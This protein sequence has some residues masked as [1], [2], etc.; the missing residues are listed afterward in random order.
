MYIGAAVLL[1]LVAVGIFFF[2]RSSATPNQTGLGGFFGFGS[3]VPT[4]QVGTSTTNTPQPTN[5]TSQRIFKIADGPVAGAAFI[6]TSNPTTTVVRYAMADNGHV[7]DKPIDVPGAI[8]SP[9]SNVTIPGI[10]SSVWATTGSST[11]MQYFDSGVLK[12]V[13]IELGSTTASSSSVTPTRVRFLPNNI[14][15]L[16]LS[17]TNSRL[18]YVLV[19]SNG[20]VDGY[21]SNL[22]GTNV[23]LAFS[24]PLSQVLLSWPSPG[25]LLLQTK[26]AVGIPG[27]A[28]S[29][30]AT[31]GVMSPMLYTPG[32]SATA[33][34]TFTKVVYQTS[35]DSKATTYSHD[36]ATGKDAVLADNPLPEK[37]VWNSAPVTNIYCAVSLDTVAS[38]YLDLWHKG[39]TRTVDS[40]VDLDTNSGI[41]T[42]V[43]LPDTGGVT[44][45]I[46]SLILSPDRHYLLFI[47]RGDQA[48]WGVHLY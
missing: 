32:L 12:S 3:S 44:A 19:N 33:N 35:P 29:I 11:I 34:S 8:A 14:I 37:C 9:V 15:S 17:P 45:S 40:I 39:L 27:V 16:A 25:T 48:L 26:S 5:S 10:V 2:S 21:I 38:N 13:Y 24:A 41:S 31:T 23:K 1:V 43:T 28:Y 6:Q 20:G 18:A 22:D 42:V 30:N 47:T 46:E 4:T 36:I 7:L